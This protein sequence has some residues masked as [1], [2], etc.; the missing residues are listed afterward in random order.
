VSMTVLFLKCSSNFFYFTHD[1]FSFSLSSRLSGGDDDAHGNQTVL[2]AALNGAN[3]TWEITRYSGVEHGFTEWGSDAFS[4]K[5]DV[6]SW[7]SMLTALQELMVAPVNCTS[8]NS[9]EEVSTPSSNAPRGY[10]AF[11]TI[12]F[13][14]LIALLV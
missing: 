2:E 14:V 11:S 1:L 5:A 4:L 12:A 10:L 13:G 3:A 6:R 9:C 8:T 7:E